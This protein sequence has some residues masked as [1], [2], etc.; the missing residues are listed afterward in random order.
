MNTPNPSIA[1]AGAA[2]STAEHL[3][4]L[5]D[6]AIGPADLDALMAD[7]RTDP[8]SLERWHAYQVIGATLRRSEPVVS[9]CGSADFLE[10]VRARLHAQAPERL[11][12]ADEPLPVRASLRPAANDGVFRWKLVAGLASVAAVA[13][14]GWNLLATVPVGDATAR[15]S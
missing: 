3:S 2:V 10:G 6:G 7:C 5:C 14:V 9:R 8:Q 15:S 1:E 13:A 4:A 12:V 11:V